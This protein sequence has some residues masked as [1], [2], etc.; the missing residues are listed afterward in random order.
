[1]VAF[2]L[3]GSDR[4]EMFGIGL[5]FAVNILFS[6]TLGMDFM[7]YLS[8]NMN[9]LSKIDRISIV[10]VLICFVLNIVSSV[11]LM[12]TMN[13]LQSK[14]NIRGIPLALSKTSRFRLTQIEQIFISLT[15][16][17]AVVSMIIY[18]DAKTIIVTLADAFGKY[19]MPKNGP[20]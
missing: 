8:K 5:F 13:G 2:S 17:L 9:I 1:V 20:F 3:M 7:K 4:L 10:A 16:F 18:F 14:F 11:F 12:I 19:M 15:I 6:F